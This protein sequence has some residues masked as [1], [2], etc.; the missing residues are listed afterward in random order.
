MTSK[1]SITTKELIQNYQKFGKSSNVHTD[2]CDWQPG[3]VIS[4]DDNSVAFYFRNLSRAQRN[5]T[6]TEQELLSIVEALKEF[7]NILLG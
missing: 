7:S 1:E 5:D 2:A 4:Q 3:E 6:A